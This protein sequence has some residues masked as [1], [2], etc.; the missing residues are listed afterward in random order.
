L[1]EQRARLRS[2]PPL[3][4][5]VR[6]AS[7]ALL[8]VFLSRYGIVRA[9]SPNA[10]VFKE[11]ESMNEDQ[12][13]L[14]RQWNDKTWLAHSAHRIAAARLESYARYVGGV[15]A[16]ISGVT[17]LTLVGSSGTTLAGALATSTNIYIQLLCGMLTFIAGVLSGLQSLN[18]SK[19]AEEQTKMAFDYGVIR[20]EIDVKLVSQLNVEEAQKTIEDIKQ[21]IDELA[22]RKV[23]PP[24]KDLE[25]AKQ[26]RAKAL[27][28]QKP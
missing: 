11:R 18:F 26:Q 6:R 24:T 17:G 25:T 16:I 13:K 21:K 8:P 23:Q 10:D 4:V 5:T 14:L 2:P 27:A 1:N 7:V 22:R 28:E 12:A 19:Q 9:S 3:S 15:S 20:R